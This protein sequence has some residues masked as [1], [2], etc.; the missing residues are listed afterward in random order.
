MYDKE[1]VEEILNQIYGA[2]EKIE[3]R[4]S[5]VE[6]VEDFFATEAGSEKL[7][8]ICMQLTAIG[9][10]VK[11][12]DKITDKK[13]LVDYPEVEWKKVKGIRDVITHHYFIHSCTG[14]EFV[15]FT[16]IH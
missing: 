16:I 5:A 10:S 13:L 9:E 12:L 6:H 7:D 11:N 8:S 1:L 14:L 3:K 4:F 15:F 2:A